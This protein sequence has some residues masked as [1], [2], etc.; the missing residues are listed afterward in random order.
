MFLTPKKLVK[1]LKNFG[2]KTEK[3]A[4]S[5]KIFRKFYTYINLSN[6]FKYF[7]L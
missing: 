2:T 5:N 1:S 6:L 4:S 7:D 3:P